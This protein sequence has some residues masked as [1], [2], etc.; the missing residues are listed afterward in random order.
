MDPR[1]LE[2]VFAQEG[3]YL[4]GRSIRWGDVALFGVSGS[5]PT[6]MHTPYEIPESEIEQLAEKGWNDSG[7]ARIKVFIPHAPPSGTSLDR[8]PG[9]RHVGS[10]AVRAFIERRQPDL[11]LCGHIHEG[12][13]Q[14]RIGRSVVVNCGP[15]HH[16][17]YVVIHTVPEIRLEMRP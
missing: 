5:P 11:V 14:E 15:A 9:G 12:R 8:L 16:G 7:N 17:N 1:S 6:P 4:H 10:E 13:G 3:Q 2:S